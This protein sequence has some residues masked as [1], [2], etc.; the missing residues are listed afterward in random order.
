[1]NANANSATFLFFF[2]QYSKTAHMAI[3]YANNRYFLPV[4]PS[5]RGEG[6]IALQNGEGIYQTNVK[7]LITMDKLEAP[8]GHALVS[9]CI[10][11]FTWLQDLQWKK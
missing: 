7:V 9:K 3:L 4:T 8:A 2:V 6:C 11:P 1:M 5:L 10:L